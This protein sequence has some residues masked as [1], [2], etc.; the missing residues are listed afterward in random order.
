MFVDKTVIFLNYLLGRSLH[1]LAVLL[2][3]KQHK[4][5]KMILAVH[6]VHQKPKRTWI[7]KSFSLLSNLDNKELKGS[8]C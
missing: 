1:L 3:I 8:K 2:F 5:N 7:R 6:M 4:Y